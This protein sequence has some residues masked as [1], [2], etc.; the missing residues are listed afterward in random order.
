VTTMICAAMVI[1]Q[2]HAHT[3]QIRQFL[4]GYTISSARCAK[5]VAHSRPPWRCRCAVGPIDGRM[6]RRNI[7][8]HI[9]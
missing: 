6:P 8:K 2:T 5:S 1:R 4:T 9:N 3:P 7:S